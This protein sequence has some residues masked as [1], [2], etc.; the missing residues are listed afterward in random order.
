M[1]LDYGWS[2]L[3]T[4]DLLAHDFEDENTSGQAAPASAAAPRS[5][6]SSSDDD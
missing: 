3:D 1:E 2:D 5:N 4:A 6:V